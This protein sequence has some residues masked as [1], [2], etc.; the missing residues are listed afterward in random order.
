MPLLNL[1][2]CQTCLR[3]LAY[4]GLHYFMLP[5]LLTHAR[6]SVQSCVHR[7]VKSFAVF[8]V[9]IAYLGIRASIFAFLLSLLLK[10]A[11]SQKMVQKITFNSLY[12]FPSGKLSIDRSTKKTKKRKFPYFISLFHLRFREVYP[13][14]I[15]LKTLKVYDSY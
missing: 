3:C 8:S 10:F 14:A 9:P 13:Y 7:S 12:I 5:S 11:E 15:S 6:S 4:T 1:S 2:I